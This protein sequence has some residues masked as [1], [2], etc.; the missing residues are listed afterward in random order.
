[1]DFH[2]A[3]LRNSNFSHVEPESANRPAQIPY[4]SN[5]SVARVAPILQDNRISFK[6]KHGKKAS[7]RPGK[8]TDKLHQQS[9]GM[10][11]DQI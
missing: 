1:M 3:S 8:E 5:A 4:N 10:N 2:D 7:L 6:D 9:R 11:C